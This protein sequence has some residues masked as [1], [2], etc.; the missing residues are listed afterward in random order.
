MNSEKNILVRILL[1]VGR[2]TFKLN[3]HYQ[4]SDALYDSAIHERVL[5]GNLQKDGYNCW[6]Q[7]GNA[8]PPKEN[9]I[10]IY[11]HFIQNPI[12]DG[13]QFIFK[14]NEWKINYDF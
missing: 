7:N 8:N 5:T 13:L 10:C 1:S 14:N 9:D 6:K 2:E 12:D 4:G 11:S 3:R